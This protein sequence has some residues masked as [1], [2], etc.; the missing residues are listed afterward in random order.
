[1]YAVGVLVTIVLS[2]DA[3]AVVLT[4][5]VAAAVRKAKAEPLPYLFACAFI[6]NAASFV[7]PISNPANFVIFAGAM[8][9]LPR[10]L[11]AFA[12][13]SLV[14]IVATFVVLAL[15]SRRDLRGT[16]ATDV[17][18]AQLGKSG[19]LA[20][21]GIGL[22]AVALLTASA[23]DAPLGATTCACGVLVFGIASLRDRAAFDGILRSISWTVLVLV[24]GLF[25]LVQGLDAT[26]VLNLTRHGVQTLAAWPPA[27][28]VLG[29]AGVTAAA[30]NVMNNLPSGLI[31]GESVATLHGHNALRSAIAIG[32]DLGPNLS[33][34]GSLATVL[35][36]IALRREQIDVTAWTFLRAGA[37]VMPPA[38]VLA[39]LS[40]L[41]TTQ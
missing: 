39:V 38:L 10:W 2:N 40:I 5:A 27:L 41:T 3:T 14:S 34:T 1:V 29:A 18:I 9:S 35:W 24:A 20:L 31:A 25:V 21:A 6:A 8:P 11:A 30:S 32:I 23:F 26:G 19:G 33:V 17:D 36:L 15:I 4:P 28:A 37:L 12:L 13:P 16:T 22:T 7:L